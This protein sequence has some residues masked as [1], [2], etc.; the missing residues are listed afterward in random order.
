MKIEIV[1]RMEKTEKTKS[2]YY[3]RPFAWGSCDC[4]KIAG[5]HARK[6]GWKVPK[7]GDYHS[8]LGA[9][10]KLK[11]S[12]CENLEE[13]VAKI[14][15]KEIPPSQAM[16]GDIV[17]FDSDSSLGGLGIAIGNGNMLAFHEAAEGAAII[18]MSNIN[19]AW[20]IYNG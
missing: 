9:A 15:M 14:G 11:A 20:S 2:K 17:S 5:F 6:F 4:G 13:L 19:K 16:I 3:G 8:A 12:G 18:S 1:E 10:K 7:T